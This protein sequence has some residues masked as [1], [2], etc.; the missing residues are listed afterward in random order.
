MEFND[1]FL[2]GLAHNTVKCW[3]GEAICDGINGE[4]HA[5]CWCR[6]QKQLLSELSL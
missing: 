3:V 4:S 5:V 1:I 6:A 2:V